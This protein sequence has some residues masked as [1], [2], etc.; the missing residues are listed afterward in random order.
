MSRSKIASATASLALLATCGTMS[1]LAG[2]SEGP[3][4]PM[5][6][7]WQPPDPDVIPVT[8]DS[9]E[10]ET[11]GPTN[12]DVIPVTGDSSGPETPPPSNPDVIPV[13][14]DSSGPETPAPT[15]PAPGAAMAAASSVASLSAA[16][17]EILAAHNAERASVGAPPLRWNPLL[18]SHAAEYARQLAHSGQLVHASREGRGVEREN[19]SEGNPGWTT[20]QMINSWLAEKRFFHAGVFPNVCNGEWST[21]AH[22]SQMIWPTTTDIGCAEAS[23]SAHTWLVCRYSPGGN[24]DGKPVGAAPR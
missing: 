9:S 2:C 19:L 24:K 15:N 18:A 3:P 14:G 1:M 5:E 4:P 23:G 13:T 21:C 12:P 8:G 7:E 6:P 22:Y 11:P 16:G 17:V 10:P 20:G